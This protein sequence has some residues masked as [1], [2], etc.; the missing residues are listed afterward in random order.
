LAELGSPIRPTSASLRE[1]KRLVIAPSKAA[2]DD[3]FDTQGSEPTGS[4]YP[5]EYTGWG[6]SQDK[7]P[8]VLR[9]GI[10]RRS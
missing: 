8:R 6:L 5:K 3:F 7:H 2:W 10:P 1:G 9:G 4:L